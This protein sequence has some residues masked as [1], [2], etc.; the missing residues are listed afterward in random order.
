MK[1]W[2]MTDDHADDHMNSGDMVEFTHA[3]KTIFTRLNNKHEQRTISPGEIA[4]VV[5]KFDGIEPVPVFCFSSM[6]RI[7]TSAF[8]I[9]FSDGCSFEVYGVN[10]KK[11]DNLMQEIW[12]E[13]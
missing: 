1:K 4:I 7:K 12:K 2:I 11:M 10:L 13:A 8:Q 5:G 9:I 3:K 6:K